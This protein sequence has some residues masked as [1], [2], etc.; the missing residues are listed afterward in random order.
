MKQDSRKHI[1]HHNICDAVWCARSLLQTLQAFGEFGDKAAQ[2]RHQDDQER[3]RLVIHRRQH[4]VVSRTQ[5]HKKSIALNTIQNL[6]KLIDIFVLF[7]WRTIIN[8]D[9]NCFNYLLWTL[10]LVYTLHLFF[11]LSVNFTLKFIGFINET[12]DYWLMLFYVAWI[13]KE[14]TAVEIKSLMFKECLR[15]RFRRKKKFLRTLHQRRCGLFSQI[16]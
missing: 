10:Q 3:N 11:F 15:S 14:Y 9:N 6:S 1:A 5:K 4:P 8:S 13:N 7:P 12:H 2:R 16:H